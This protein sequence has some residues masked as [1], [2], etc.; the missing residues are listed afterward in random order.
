MT[1][2]ITTSFN[3]NLDIDI[4]MSTRNN[5]NVK[6]LEETTSFQL[7]A[8]Y[9]SNVVDFTERKLL[10]YA[11]RITDAQQRL[12]IMALIKDY[13]DGNVVVAWKRGLPIYI[14]VMREK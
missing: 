4:G 14:K 6:R 13:T 3:Q 10:M 1:T 11:T 2:Y 9:N 5:S 8:N 7:Y 12:M